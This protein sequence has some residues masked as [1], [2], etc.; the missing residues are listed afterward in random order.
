[1]STPDLMSTYPLSVGYP[2]GGIHYLILW[3]SHSTGHHLILSRSPKA[4][5]HTFSRILDKWSDLRIKQ[6]CEIEIVA[7]PQT[8]CKVY[9][10][11]IHA[12]SVKR[13]WDWASYASRG[14]S[15]SPIP[16]A[17]NLPPEISICTVYNPD[18]FNGPED[19]RDHHWGCQNCIERLLPTEGTFDSVYWKFR[20]RFNEVC[21]PITKPPTLSRA[22]PSRYG[23]DLWVITT[24]FGAHRKG[25]RISPYVDSE[26][27]GGSI[28]FV[29]RGSRDIT[30]LEESLRK[31]NTRREDI[32]K[33]R[34]EQVR[35]N[36]LVQWKKGY[37]DMRLI[38]G[39]T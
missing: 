15:K 14:P 19:A 16:Q 11:H 4:A 32:I 10:D 6:Y 12:E 23:E 3:G 17:Y 7:P 39:L 34:R 8:A 33:D 22:R 29:D 35:A 18:E 26:F 25:I 20:D 21:G 2:H 5:E 30:G 13:F 31:E 1:M 38:F 24:D 36:A 28:F 27:Y 9:A 37:D